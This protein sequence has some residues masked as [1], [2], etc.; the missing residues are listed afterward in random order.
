MK[1]K[2]RTIRNDVVNLTNILED[3]KSVDIYGDDPTVKKEVPSSQ[4]LPCI[5]DE[6]VYEI[7]SFD[8]AQKG[9][10]KGT[11]EDYY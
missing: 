9:E 7:K 11:D 1:M 10:L 2:Q 3:E 5:T 8:G 6:N 4:D